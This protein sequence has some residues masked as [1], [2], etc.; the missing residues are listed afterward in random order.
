MGKYI[1]KSDTDELNPVY[2]FHLIATDLL[3]AIVKKKIDP[4]ELA[5]KELA[6]RDLN[7][8]GEWVGFKV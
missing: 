2:L 8:N 1:A 7:E 6:N 4:I 5:N 3:V